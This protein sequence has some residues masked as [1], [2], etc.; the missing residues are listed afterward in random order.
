[1]DILI[2]FDINTS[3]LNAVNPFSVMETTEIIILFLLF[4]FFI[5]SISSFFQRKKET[6][7][8]EKEDES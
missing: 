3:I 4:L 1:M 7:K 5:F 8:D 6:M 2:G